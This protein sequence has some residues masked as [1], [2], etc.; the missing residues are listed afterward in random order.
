MNNWLAPQNS[1]KKWLG[2]KK[3]KE[4]VENKKWQRWKMTGPKKGNQQFKIKN[5]TIAKWLIPKKRKDTIENKK[6]Q[7][8]KMRGPAHPLRRGGV[9][10]GA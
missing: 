2:K 8:W 6:W 3:K 7:N 5:G 4:T 10:G 9:E 1:L